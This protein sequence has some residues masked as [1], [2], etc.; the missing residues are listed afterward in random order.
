[1]QSA[2][3]MRF[4]ERQVRDSMGLEYSGV[5]QKKNK[6]GFYQNRFIRTSGCYIQY[7]TSSEKY[8]AEEEHPSSSYDI[9]EIKLIE[10]RGDGY[11]FIQFMNE[12][13]KLELRAISEDQCQEWIHFLNSKRSLHSTNS[14]LNDSVVN[15]SFKTSTFA[16]LLRLT[17]EEQDHWINDFMN[18]SFEMVTEPSSIS[19]PL[20]LP[21][22]SGN[23]IH[24]E[25]KAVLT[26]CKECLEDFTVTCEE[27]ALEMTARIPQIIAQCR[28]Y[29]HR[30]AELF[31]ARLSLE[32][33]PFFSQSL[34]VTFLHSLGDDTLITAICFFQS[35]DTLRQHKFLPR[36][37]FT[38]IRETLYSADQLTREFLK[39]LVIRNELWYCELNELQPRQRGQKL[40]E[41]YKIVDY[42]IK[43]IDDTFVICDLYDMKSKQTLLMMTIDTLALSMARLVAKTSFTSYGEEALLGHILA[44]QECVRYF[45]T[46]KLAQHSSSLLM[47]EGGG[48]GEGSRARAQSVQSTSSSNHDGLTLNYPFSPTSTLT[49][50]TIPPSPFLPPPPPPSSSFSPAPSH[51]GVLA[52]SRTCIEQLGSIFLQSAANAATGAVTNMLTSTQDLVNMFFNEKDSGWLGGKVCSVYLDRLTS[53][54]EGFCQRGSLKPCEFHRIVRREMIRSVVITYLRKLIDRYRLN[55][56]F[57]LTSAGETQVASDLK[58]INRW[59]EIQNEKLVPSYILDHGSYTGSNDVTMI[60]KYIRLFITSDESNLMLC[61]LESI[62]HFGLASAPHLYDLVRLSLKIRRDLTK[63]CR[64]DVLASFSTYIEQLGQV[65][66]EDL[67][68]LTQPHPRLSGPEILQELCPRVGV[69]HCTGKKWSYEVADQQTKLE[70]ANLVTDACN[71]ARIRRLGFSETATSSRSSALKSHQHEEGGGRGYDGW[72]LLDPDSMRA[73]MTT[74]PKSLSDHPQPPIDHRQLV[75]VVDAIDNISV[76]DNL[77]PDHL[78]SSSHDHES[79]PSVYCYEGKRPLIDLYGCSFE[80]LHLSLCP[81]MFVRRSSRRYLFLSSVTPTEQPTAM[82]SFSELE[83]CYEEKSG[84]EEGEEERHEQEQGQLQ[85]HYLYKQQEEEQEEEVEEEEAN[86]DQRREEFSEDAS[87]DSS[88]ERDD[89]KVRREEEPETLT[90]GGEEQVEQSPW[91]EADVVDEWPTPP[92]ELPSPV[93]VTTE[94]SSL[95]PEKPPKPRRYSIPKANISTLEME[96]SNF[97]LDSPEDLDPE[98]PSMEIAEQLRFAQNQLPERCR[99]PSISFS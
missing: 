91:S 44:C 75:S 61:F 92:Q 17:A 87:S 77:P 29:M 96:K 30:Y 3:L 70:M 11:F 10:S 72:Q 60:V 88:S 59:V 50:I 42:Q 58:M 68:P 2:A 48:G 79:A 6:K 81:P 83:Q 15:N 34:P 66:P 38:I 55:K 28:D 25:V 41:Y 74:S 4:G 21:S 84:H 95:P 73:S 47:M 32:L 49:T 78:N 46:L 8:A 54:T 16:A 45:S 89:Q 33:N 22:F 76:L 7:W 56:R 26:A 67:Q 18:D 57:Q 13:F 98:D 51:G 35:L 85:E 93:I 14:L 9:K 24:S 97:S 19:S 69:Y 37:F 12:K 36:S 20:S 53:W 86:H 31:K 82:V 23:K 43:M 40:C 90:I 63:K 1:M 80:E 64:H 62:Q 39:L 94:F 52:L 65:S 27:C 99:H 5:L 71:V